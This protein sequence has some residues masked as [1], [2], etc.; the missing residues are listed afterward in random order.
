MDTQVISKLAEVKID[1]VLEK[2]KP[3]H[4]PSMLS[5]DAVVA[6]EALAHYF[7]KSYKFFADMQNQVR[8][9]REQRSRLVKLPKP[10]PSVLFDVAQMEGIVLPGSPY[11]VYSQKFMQ[12]TDNKGG[13]PDATKPEKARPAK[14]G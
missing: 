11:D 4:I 7:D 12:L 10:R 6:G 13:H 1:D 9:F 5:E 3:E 14:L 2:F 8:K